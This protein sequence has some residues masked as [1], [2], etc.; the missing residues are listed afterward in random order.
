MPKKTFAGS[1]VERIGS[2]REKFFYRFLRSVGGGHD[3]INPTAALLV[4]MS[5]TMRALLVCSRLK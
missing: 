5:G 4:R 1:A 2:G 3:P